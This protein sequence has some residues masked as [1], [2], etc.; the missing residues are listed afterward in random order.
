MRIKVRSYKGLLVELDSVVDIRR[1]IAR[2]AVRIIRYQV[3]I[4]CDDGAEITL[5]DVAPNEIE[6][7]T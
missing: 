3:A 5:R 4:L 6:V 2:N 7:L 1:D